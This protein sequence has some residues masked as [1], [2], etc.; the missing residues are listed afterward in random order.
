M[1]GAGRGEQSV[2]GRHAEVGKAILLGRRNVRQNRIALVRCDGIGL[3]CPNLELRN[4]RD[5]DIACVIDLT[6]DKCIDRAHAREGYHRWLHIQDRMEQQACGE[7][8]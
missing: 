2:P 1:I 4:G 3:D 8:R 5:Y 6:G 7:H